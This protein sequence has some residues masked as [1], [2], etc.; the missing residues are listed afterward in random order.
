M[1]NIKIL[2]YMKYI[3]LWPLLQQW[4]VLLTEVNT[5]VND[6]NPIENTNIYK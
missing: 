1:M 2:D 4:G 3:C 6:A 5:K